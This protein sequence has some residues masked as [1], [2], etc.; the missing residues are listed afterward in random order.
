MIYDLAPASH[1]PGQFYWSVYTQDYDLLKRG[2]AN[3]RKEAHAAAKKYIKT[4]TDS[5]PKEEPTP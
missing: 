3:S 2:I 4:S 1:S 5:T